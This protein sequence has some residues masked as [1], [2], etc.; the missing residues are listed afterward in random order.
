M[1]SRGI[2]I[3]RKCHSGIHDLIPDEKVLAETYNTVE[4]L[5]AHEGIARH[6]AW[7]KKQR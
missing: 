6:V 3:C 1:H 7:V 4:S 2:L 5:L